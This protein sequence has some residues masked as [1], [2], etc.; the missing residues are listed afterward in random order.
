MFNPDSPSPAGIPLAEWAGLLELSSDLLA[1]LDAEGR[2][3]WANHAFAQACGCDAASLKGHTLPELLGLPAG[4]VD[5]LVRAGPGQEAIAEQRW[6]HATAGPRIGRASV[7]PVGGAAGED[8]VHVAFSLQDLTELKLARAASQTHREMNTA[9]ALGKVATWRHDLVLDR[10]FYNGHVFHVLGLPP[11]DE[12]IPLEQMRALI[13]PADIAQ[14]LATAEHALHTDQPVDMEARYRRPDGSWIYVLTRR[15]VHRDATGRPIEFLGV[16]LDVTAQ[17]E[18][19]RAASEW[20]KRLELAISAAGVGVWSQDAGP[21]RTQ[22]N[23]EMYRITGRSPALGGPTYDE[24]LV[25]ILHPEDRDA[26]VKAGRELS[27]EALSREH[28]C[29]IVRPDGEVRWL[30][31]RARRELH[32][33]RSSTFGI[34]I[35]VTERIRAEAELRRANE[36]VALAAR[37]VGLGTWEWNVVTGDAV[38]DEAMFRLRG[39]EPCERAL[40]AAE[41]LAMTHPSDVE[42]VKRA[43]REAATNT[44]TT[45]YEFRVVWPD[46]TVRWIASRSTPLPD[47]AERNCRIGVNWD[48]TDAKNA[49]IGRAERELALRESKAKSEFLSRMSHELRTPLN[50]ILGFAQLMRLEDGALDPAQHTRIAHIQSAGEHL[51]SLIDDVLDLSSLESGK[52]QL[53]LQPVPL[54]EVAT[55][56]MPLVEHLA[57]RRGVKVVG[58]ALE[59]VAMA[60][61]IHLRQVVI[62]LLINAIRSTAPR[63]SVRLS[64]QQSEGQV[65]L[66]VED[67]GR[68]L[69]PTQLAHLFEPFHHFGNDG[70]G[71]AGTGVGLAVVKAL[72]ERMQGS[73]D[74]RSAPGTGTCFELRLPSGLDTRTAASNTPVATPQAAPPHRATLLYIE[75]NPVNVLLLQEL[76]RMRPGLRLESAATGTAGVAQA[77]ALQPDLVLIDIQLPD[78]DGFEVLRRL[79]NQT[80]TRTLPC[81]A[82]S[83]NAMPQDVARA[84]ASGFADYWTKPIHFG[85]FLAAL[86]QRFPPDSTLR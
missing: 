42:S 38:W 35:D 55:E 18:K 50:A 77:A 66:R 20:A 49:E 26:T 21:H 9:M 32:E 58:E 23:A 46:G 70:E 31:S 24:W 69:T 19:L 62:N 28:T 48:V 22:W 51:L 59:G 3:V 5:T 6:R 81:I 57:R 27:A 10:I 84:K 15:V 78:I 71:T 37:S 75:D 74:V 86:D 12:G 45:A 54:A 72:V 16:A 36:R 60:D 2:V 73:I 83:A 8:G 7:R 67:D 53:D 29:R 17:V 40:D 82:L 76:V 64:S 80:S 56:A 52:V 63:G 39:M 30:V 13:H 47:G 11:S 68:S 14:V 44:G 33:G 65:T 1:L 85:N 34:S 25:D 4:L 41:R 79:R 43:L 61:R